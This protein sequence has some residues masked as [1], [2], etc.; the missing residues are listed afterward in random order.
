VSELLALVAAAV[1]A[2]LAAALVRVALGPT[3]FDRMLAAQLFGSGGVAI[4]ALLAFAMG[5]PALLDAALALA[6]LAAVAAVAF[7]RRA[8]TGVEE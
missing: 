8:R 1:L 6:F 4:L 7:V 3:D 2:T 5:V